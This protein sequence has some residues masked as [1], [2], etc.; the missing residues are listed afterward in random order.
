[1][2]AQP[3]MDY[4]CCLFSASFV[5]QSGIQQLVWQELNEMLYLNKISWYLGFQGAYN[6]L[7]TKGLCGLLLFFNM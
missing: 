1:M 2:T 7:I 3:H 4:M 6:A 5:R